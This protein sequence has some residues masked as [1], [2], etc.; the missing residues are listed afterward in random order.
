MK[1][2]RKVQ[3][4]T[5]IEIMIVVT[6]IIL[7]AGIAIPSFIRA[8]Q[9]TQGSTTLNGARMLDSAIDQW[10]IENAIDNGTAIV[11]QSLA[12]YIVQPGPM[13]AFL[14]AGVTPTDALSNEY[15]F[16]VVGSGQLQIHPVTKASLASAVSDWGP[17]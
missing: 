8:R 2:H 13:Q 3:G 9:R 10:A 1:G 5:L 11:L 6:I 15:V 7:L 17:Y 16:N 14:A 12:I 4:F